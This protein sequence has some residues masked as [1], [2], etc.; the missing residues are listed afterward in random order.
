MAAVWIMIY[1]KLLDTWPACIAL[2]QQYIH[3]R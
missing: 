2:N 3:P 1:Q